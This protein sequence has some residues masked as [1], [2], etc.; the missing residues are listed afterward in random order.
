MR[1][2]QLISSYFTGQIKHTKM[3]SLALG[4]KTRKRRRQTPQSDG[5]MFSYLDVVV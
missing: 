1:V 5:M 4:L 2:E 3:D